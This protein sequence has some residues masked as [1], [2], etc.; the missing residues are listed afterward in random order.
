[1]SLLTH[2]FIAEM[3]GV[4]RAGITE[5]A[6]GFQKRGWTR[7]HR[8][9]LTVL[10]RP[11]LEQTSCECYG[12]VRQELE[13]YLTTIAPHLPGPAA[14]SLASFEDLSNGYEN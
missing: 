3:L 1:M 5:A 12:V 10:D 7:Y 4:R 11:G 6:I 2:E 8:G 14:L 9:H 13:S